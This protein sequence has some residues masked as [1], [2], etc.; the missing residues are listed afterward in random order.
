MPLCFSCGKELKIVESVGRG[1][2]CPHCGADMHCCRNCEFYDPNAYNEC[3]EPMAE[4]V[5]EKDRSNFCDY[6]QMA[7][8]SYSAEGKSSEAKRKLDE[9]FTKK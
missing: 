1:E 6:F 4:R 5:L 2:A 3:R 7:E 9:L 8:K